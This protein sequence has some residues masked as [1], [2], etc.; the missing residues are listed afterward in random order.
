[1]NAPSPNEP[2]PRWLELYQRILQLSGPVHSALLITCF[3][4]G[5]SILCTAALIIV[6]E[7]VGFWPMILVGT[8]VPSVLCPPVGYAMATLVRALASTQ[9]QLRQMA[10]QDELTRA[11]NRRYFLTTANARLDAAHKAA[12][13]AAGD[14]LEP[15][16]AHSIVL[17][18]IDNFKQINDRYGHPVGDAVLREISAT[19][20]SLLRQSDVFARYGGEEFV[21]LLNQTPPDQAAAV[22]ERMRLAIGELQ[23][24]VPGQAPI[25]VSASFGIA[26]TDC[27]RD[28]APNA[29]RSSSL[30]DQILAAADAALYEAKRRGKNRAWFAGDCSNKAEGQSA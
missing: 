27:V 9:G 26:G 8:I 19:C 11:H 5:M 30:L 3:I 4:T 14:K 12:H 20:R 7:P 25:S 2:L 21:L 28:P 22:V 13:R 6:L 1:M 15:P 17:L 10:E 24:P 18:D 29:T 23:V 16:P